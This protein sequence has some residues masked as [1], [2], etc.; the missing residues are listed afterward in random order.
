M[1]MT[2]RTVVVLVVMMMTTPTKETN[3]KNSKWH[4]CRDELQFSARAI[5]VPTSS[6]AVSR[7]SSIGN[8]THRICDTLM[9]GGAPLIVRKDTKNFYV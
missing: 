5:E 8:I 3:K 1:G 9:S 4:H 7:L 2:M 6:V